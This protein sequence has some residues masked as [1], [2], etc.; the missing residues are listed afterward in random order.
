MTVAAHPSAPLLVDLHPQ[1][2]SAWLAL[3]AHGWA[4]TRLHGV[5][6]GAGYWAPSASGA[7]VLR[8]DLLRDLIGPLGV[9]ASA[10][11]SA[12]GEGLPS[13][14]PDESAWDFWAWTSG[15]LPPRLDASPVIRHL[16]WRCPP[17][18]PTDDAHALEGLLSELLAH[19]GVRWSIHLPQALSALVVDHGSLDA[20]CT[21]LVA[22][23]QALPAG[24]LGLLELGGRQHWTAAYGPTNHRVPGVLWDALDAL[25]A[26]GH[27]PAVRLAWEHDV[28]PLAVVLDEARLARDILG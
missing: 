9:L 11:W 14:A 4:D 12:S 26:S 19:P 22:R 28:P 1:H 24:C 17:L 18:P 27:A 6:L 16:V 15:H 20:A 3:G 10:T 25:H 7:S 8:A 5:H 13:A 2:A 21:E 23:I